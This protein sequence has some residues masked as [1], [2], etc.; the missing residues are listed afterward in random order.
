MCLTVYQEFGCGH[1]KLPE[2]R[3]KPRFCPCAQPKSSE[4][5]Y[6]KGYSFAPLCEVCLAQLS[7]I[8]PIV[9]TNAAATAT[10]STAAVFMSA[11]NTLDVARAGWTKPTQKER[12]TVAGRAAIRL[13]M[14]STQNGM[15][16]PRLLM[17]NAAE[18]TVMANIAPQLQ[19]PLSMG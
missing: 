6:T 11:R 7:T 15:Y 10:T 19:R 5:E 17:V 4:C 16:R 18:T 2:Y 3:S 9:I 13:E 8:E 14:L 1:H 12:N